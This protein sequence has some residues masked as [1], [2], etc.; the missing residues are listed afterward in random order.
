MYI[1]IWYAGI[2]MIIRR[3]LS[4]H[5]KRMLSKFPVVS[6]TGPRRSG[7]TTLLKA[8]FIHYDYYNLER[9]ETREG[10]H[11]SYPRCA[12]LPGSSY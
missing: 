4:E 2:H 12:L 3:N 10:M 11:Q 5:L 1:C 7:K 8:D 9:I 6:L